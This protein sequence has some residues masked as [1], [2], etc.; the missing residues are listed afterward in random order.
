KDDRFR[1]K[2]FE[3]AALPV[4]TERTSDAITVLEQGDNRMFHV[5]LNSLVNPPIL[6]GADQ[7]QAG[8]I[9]NVSESRIAMTAEIALQNSSVRGAIEDGTPRFKFTNAFR[10]FLCMQFSHS[11]VV[12]VLAA[13]HCVGE[14][15]LPIVAIVDVR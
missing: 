15:N 9:A 7:F 13:A 5:D 3:S 1:F 12:D 6:E 14:M 8:T 2:H 4:V 11:P 10:R